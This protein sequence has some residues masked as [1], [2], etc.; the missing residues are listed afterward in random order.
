LGLY[1]KGSLAARE[2]RAKA[3]KETLSQIKKN[4]ERGKKMKTKIY[5][6]MLV[7][8]LSAALIGGATMAWFT[9]TVSNTG[10]VFAAGTIDV[11]LQ[12]A[13]NVVAPIFNF[14]NIA[15]GWVSPTTTVNVRNAG[16][17]PMRVRGIVSGQATATNDIALYNA[18]EGRYRVVINGV[19]ITEWSGW[20]DAPSLPITRILSDIASGTTVSI[21]LQFML[22]TTTGNAAQGGNVTLDLALTA[23]QLENQ[24]WTE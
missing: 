1:D 7:I 10:N 17:L 15:P 12:G 18:L 8:A 5:V 19:P 23:T 21:D 3:Q 11:Q 13:D 4:N 6:S 16:T 14:Q 20:L 24:G 22:P 9:D 2:M